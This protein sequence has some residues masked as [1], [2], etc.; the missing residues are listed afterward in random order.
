MAAF[1]MNKNKYIVL[2]LCIFLKGLFPSVLSMFFFRK[3]NRVTFCSEFNTEF[4]HNSKWLFFYFLENVDNYEIRFVVNDHHQREE[5]TRCY[6]QYFITNTKFSDIFYILSSSIWFTSSLETPIGGF[7]H[8]FRR[9]VFHLGHGIP[10]KSIGLSEKKRR[11]FKKVYYFFV[12]TNFSYFISTSSIFDSVWKG[13]LNVPESK[14]IRGGQPRNDILFV[15]NSHNNYF[16]D[17]KKNILYAPTWRPYSETLIFPFTDFSADDLEVFLKELNAVIYLRLHPNFEE[18]I[19]DYISNIDGV[20]VLKKEHVSDI[21]EL[22][23]EVDLLITDYSS[24]YADFLLLNRP[25]MFIPY[26]FDV[27][28]QYI[29]FSVDYK[30][31]TPGPKPT[32]F[33]EF[34]LEIITLLSC[35]DYYSEER[36]NICN[37]FNSINKEHSKSIYDLL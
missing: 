22:L 20:I 37:I 30:M 23:G 11:N 17:N 3:P 27:Y 31:L 4:N 26:D 19:P 29:G 36:K 10:I 6:G 28:E 14:V 15:N 21:N 5:L 18:N 1:Y 33:E 34:K 35:S 9:K 7:F 16:S 32:S 8:S 12:R 2:R 24:I 25:I 13:F